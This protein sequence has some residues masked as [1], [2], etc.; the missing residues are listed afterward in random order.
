MPDGEAIAYV[1]TSGLN[2]WSVPLGGGPPRQITHFKDRTIAQ[3][4]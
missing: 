1:D 2:I 4:A 3:F